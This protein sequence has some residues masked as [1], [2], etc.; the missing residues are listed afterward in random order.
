[1]KRI[2]LAV[3]I[4]ACVVSVATAEVSRRWGAHEAASSTDAFQRDWG[5]EVKMHLTIAPESQDVLVVLL[6][7]YGTTNDTLT[8]KAGTIEVLNVYCKGFKVVRATAT[9]VN[10][11]WLA[12][13]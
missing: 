4:A 2:L 10:C 13:Q 12:R 11:K 6:P 5:R 1:M 3:L 7:N 8:I 9:A